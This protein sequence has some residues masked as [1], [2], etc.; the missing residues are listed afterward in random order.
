M[1][2]VEVNLAEVKYKPPLPNGDY[3]FVLV[4]PPTIEQAKEV[5]K[6]TGQR[7]WYVH[8]ELRPLESEW[9]SYTVFHN[10]SLSPGALEMEDAA[11]S[12]KKL[13]EVMGVEPGVKL[14]TD[15]MLSFRFAGH[16]KLES[17]NGRL[18][19]RLEKVLGPVK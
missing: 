11:I 4:K 19:P 7:E 15:D 18:N 3:T 13:Y 12:I 9:N 16:T 5:N 1:A 17:Y 8:C 6:R 2:E 10:W 14:N